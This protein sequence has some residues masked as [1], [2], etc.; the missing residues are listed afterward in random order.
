MRSRLGVGAYDDQ[1][2]MEPR[3]EEAVQRS[4]LRKLRVCVTSRHWT[5]PFGHGS[6]SADELERAATSGSAVGSSEAIDTTG[7]TIGLCAFP[8]WPQSPS[9]RPFFRRPPRSFR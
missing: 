9:L 6:V 1:Q 3:P 2:P 8:A 7:T 4:G 5:A